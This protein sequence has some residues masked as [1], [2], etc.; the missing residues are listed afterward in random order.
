MSTLDLT[1]E[2]SWRR[3][4]PAAYGSFAIEKRLQVLF[5]HL[6]LRNR[7]VLDLGCGN[8]SYTQE[9]A[10]R[11]HSV[12]GVDAELSNLTSFVAPI[13]RL[14]AFG[15]KLPFPSST[16]DVVTMIEVLEHT[17]DDHAVLAECH[18]VLR[19]GGHLALFVPNKLYPMESHPCH[20]AKHS[21]G[22]N[23]PVVSWLPASIRK[24]LCFARIYSK[25]QLLG[26][27]RDKG[28]ELEK[29]G[30]VYPPVDTF[31][32]PRKVKA[33]YRDFSWKL[34]ES[35]LQI[36]GVSIFALLKKISPPETAPVPLIPP[37]RERFQ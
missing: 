28:F 35:P 10:E 31:P 36:F 25:R 18:R 33:L 3:G 24:H 19:P 8:G 9:M 1:T 15:E 13:P 2:H 30:Y 14:L 5:K 23:V 7:R 26:M 16:F 29:L 12:I 17:T 6:S 32:L 27:T 21:I 22:R 34:E 20:I 4:G 11:A 37:I